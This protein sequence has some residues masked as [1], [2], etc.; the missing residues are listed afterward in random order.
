MA[1]PSYARFT[2]NGVTLEGDTSIGVMGGVDVSSEHIE[3]FEVRWGT[4]VPPTGSTRSRLDVQP[5]LITKRVDQSTPRLYEAMGRSTVLEG[6]IKLFDTHPASGETRH[7]F[8]LT[9]GKARV[10]GIESCSPDSL[11]PDTASRPAREVVT[12]TAASLT[13]RDEVSNTEYTQEMTAR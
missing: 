12:I 11:N 3:V 1:L 7:R 9:I 13:Y 10:Q 8:T 2:L 5:V 6:D 4:A